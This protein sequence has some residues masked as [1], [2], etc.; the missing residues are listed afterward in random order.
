[1]VR[2]QPLRSIEKS[3]V[4]DLLKYMSTTT[5]KVDLPPEELRIWQKLGDVDAPEH[6]TH[7]PD[8]QY[9]AIQTVFLGR[10]P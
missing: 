6:V 3:F 2:T 5:Q 10:V 1:M 7:H 9:R 4:C 8:F